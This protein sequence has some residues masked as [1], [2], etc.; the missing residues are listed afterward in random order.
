LN[1]DTQYTL[2]AYYSRMNTWRRG[3]LT[4]V[5]SEYFTR[6]SEGDPCAYV[7]CPEDGAT[8]TVTKGSFSTPVTIALT[9]QEGHR[10]SVIPAK[11]SMTTLPVKYEKSLS[12]GEAATL[13]VDKGWYTVSPFGPL[14]VH[15]PTDMFS[16]G[17]MD[18][19]T[20]TQRDLPSSLTEYNA[21]IRIT[22]EKDGKPILFAATRNELR[23]TDPYD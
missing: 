1:V 3:N 10:Y 5:S 19:N 11:N 18:F 8:M 20:V 21:R 15:G 17:G 7:Y 14:T 22:L 4:F 23:I 9:V 2:V 12:S 6:R 13:R 16:T